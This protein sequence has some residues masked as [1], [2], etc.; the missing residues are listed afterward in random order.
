MACPFKWFLTFSRQNKKKIFI[1]D[2]LAMIGP[3]TK[4]F[5]F[6]ILIINATFSFD[7]IDTARD[8]LTKTSTK[9]DFIKKYNERAIKVMD[10][11]NMTQVKA[12]FLYGLYQRGSK[13]FFM[14]PQYLE[15]NNFYLSTTPGEKDK[16]ISAN[17]IMHDLDDIRSILGIKLKENPYDQALINFDDDVMGVIA[18]IF[19]GAFGLSD[20][21]A[22]GNQEKKMLEAVSKIGIRIAQKYKGHSDQDLIKHITE[23][24]DVADKSYK[25]I[26]KTHIKKSLIY[27]FLA[28]KGDASEKFKALPNLSKALVTPFGP[29]WDVKLD[30][31]KDTRNKLS[32]IYA[33][34]NPMIFDDEEPVVSMGI[35]ELVNKGLEFKP[36]LLS[37][38]ETKDPVKLRLNLWENFK[39]LQNLYYDPRRYQELNYLIETIA[40]STNAKEKETFIDKTMKTLSF[41]SRYA[42]EGDLKLQTKII[43]KSAFI[44]MRNEMG[45]YIQDT[46]KNFISNDHRHFFNALDCKDEVELFEDDLPWPH[47]M[48]NLPDDNYKEVVSGA[49][50]AQ[51]LDGYDEI[52]QSYRFIYKNPVVQ[53]RSFFLDGFPDGWMCMIAR[54]KVLKRWR[55]L[56]DLF[57]GSNS[58]AV[59]NA[60]QYIFD[61]AKIEAGTIIERKI[62]ALYRY[63]KSCAIFKFLNGLKK[64]TASKIAMFPDSELAQL[65]EV[66]PLIT[67]D[68]L[69]EWI[70]NTYNQYAKERGFGPE[71]TDGVMLVIKDL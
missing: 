14:K 60:V 62:T 38:D 40:L 5:A 1:Q 7:G 47:G 50:A 20:R 23:C 43:Q 70:K 45:Y 41:A 37:D 66:K 11:K 46:F 71:T 25:D 32:P 53:F 48:D 12:G 61:A 69:A 15:W 63:A 67:K 10:E 65:D 55:Y 52:I 33:I 44:A 9:E 2:G 6:L 39:Q 18:K 36:V 35:Q 56:N 22:S 59:A 31:I 54:N 17:Q 64:E 58:K 57:K 27:T 28:A 49:C 21:K 51:F 29:G 68:V 3:V 8:V 42:F 30:D 4:A 16:K 24:Y 19:G 26:Q 34:V 13:D